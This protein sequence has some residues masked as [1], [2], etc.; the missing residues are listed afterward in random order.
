MGQDDSSRLIRYVKNLFIWATLPSLL[1]HVDDIEPPGSEVYY[2]LWMNIFVRE[3][4]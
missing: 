1:F 2:D 3:P 4:P